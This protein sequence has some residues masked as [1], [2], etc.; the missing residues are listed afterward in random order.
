MLSVVQI[1]LKNSEISP[2]AHG[3]QPDI[4]VG[5]PDPKKAYPGKHHVSLVQFTDAIV[6][7]FANGLVLQHIVNSADEMPQ[8]VTTKRVRG[9]EYHVGGQN[10][11]SNT[12]T[13]TLLPVRSREP[14]RLPGIVREKY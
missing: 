8:A 14:H 13:K 3:N 6:S 4:N 2:N 1:F 11:R 12:D 7:G 5:K 10:D 9:E